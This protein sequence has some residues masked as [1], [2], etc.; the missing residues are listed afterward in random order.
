MQF[1]TAGISVLR[2][3]PRNGALEEIAEILQQASPRLN[4]IQLSN[5]SRRY[6]H[7]TREQTVRELR[8]M[9]YLVSIVFIH[10]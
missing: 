5:V 2:Y 8:V 4:A 6:P 10:R 7:Y 1:V 3:V 9:M